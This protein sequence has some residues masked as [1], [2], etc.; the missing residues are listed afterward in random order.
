MVC[1]KT[2]NSDKF[3]T[4]KKVVVVTNTFLLENNGD[5]YFHWEWL[6]TETPLPLESEL[7]TIGLKSRKDAPQVPK[8]AEHPPRVQLT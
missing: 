7:A 1:T 4:Q 2:Q 3:L 5:L 6:Q 8:A